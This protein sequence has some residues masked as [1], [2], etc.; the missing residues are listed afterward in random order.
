ME[1]VK[2]DERGE[3]IERERPRDGG[4]STLHGADGKAAFITVQSL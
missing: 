4:G 3:R 2:T 1:T